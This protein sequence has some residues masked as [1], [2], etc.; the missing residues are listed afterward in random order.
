M[1]ASL[2]TVYVLSAYDGDTFKGNIDLGMDVM[3]TNQ[4]FRVMCIDTP[5]VRGSTRTRGLE[6]RDQVREILGEKVQIEVVGKG[7]YGRWLVWV[8]PE[9]WDTTLNAHLYQRGDAQVEA[10]SPRDREACLQRLE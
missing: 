8:W 3:L 6:V 1:I 2:L 4:T 10:Y 9:G 5:E 7:R